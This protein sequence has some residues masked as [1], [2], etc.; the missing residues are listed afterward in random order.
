MK[1]LF[2]LILMM[3]WFGM[4]QA[5]ECRELT[6]PV[7]FSYCVYEDAKSSNQD[8]LYFL[9][10]ING[11]VKSWSQAT[12]FSHA[13]YQQWEQKGVDAP[14]VVTFSFGPQWFL[15]E[16]NASRAS[17]L[18]ELTQ[19]VVLPLLEKQMQHKTGERHMMG[20]SMGGVNT[21]QLGLKPQTRN[22]VHLSKLAIICA[23]MSEVSP[24]SSQEELQNYL[25]QTQV[26]QYYLAINNTEVVKER[27]YFAINVARAVWLNEENFR[28]ADPLVLSKNYVTDLPARVYLSAQVKDRYA[29]F[30]ANQVFLE[31]LKS[32]GVD[33]Q[34][35]PVWGE[36]CD[37]DLSSLA[38]FLVE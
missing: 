22:T 38:E 36:H 2:T 14:T 13:L 26:Y 23:Q 16:K 31:N 1:Y 15:A 3:S 34:W 8:V 12:S 32:N 19:A 21:I 35:R 10:G 9:H 37:I 7:P 5:Q 28:T 20:I 33:V 27:Y 6:S 11:N 30:E 24:F 17:G 29:N 25:E 18:F 4:A